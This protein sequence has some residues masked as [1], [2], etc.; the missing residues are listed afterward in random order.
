M[1]EK[2]ATHIN[3][4]RFQGLLLARRAALLS[5]VDAEAHID[6]EFSEVTQG[7]RDAQDAGDSS[8]YEVGEDARL[9]DAQRATDKV[10]ELDAALGR[11]AEG[12]YGICIDCG[13]AI[14][15]RRLESILEA[16]RCAN[17]QELYDQ[18]SG[19]EHHATL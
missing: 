12:S 19:V 5:R 4:A 8:N 13:E 18:R 2:Q 9:G 14:E 17:C 15:E 10:R 16:A 11:I 6:Q 1:H 3:V 7:T